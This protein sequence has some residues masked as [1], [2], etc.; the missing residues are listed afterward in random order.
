MKDRYETIKQVNTQ[1]TK[2][3]GRLKWPIILLLLQGLICWI[4][5]PG[6]IPFL[7]EE[8]TAVREFLLD[9]LLPHGAADTESYRY[10]IGLLCDWVKGLPFY[11]FLAKIAPWIIPAWLLLTVIHLLILSFRLSCLRKPR[12]EPKKPAPEKAKKSAEKPA[13][14]SVSQT[15]RPK[16]TDSGLFL[17]CRMDAEN[18]FQELQNRCNVR[19][20]KDRGI[21]LSNF[22]AV[23]GE[24][25]S[26]RILHWSTD[27][28]AMLAEDYTFRFELIDGTAYIVGNRGK[29]PMKKGVPHTLK[30][31]NDAGE[32]ITYCRATWL[33]GIQND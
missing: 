33:G 4:R 3:Q 21:W 27:G 9:V 22:R 29:I 10:Y 2:C 23:N 25:P 24:V 19:R 28:S 8:V 13:A 14:A 32:P 31:M 5:N 17:K 1:L 7:T 30:H 15:L 11:P 16:A 12:K 18:R 26:D 20:Y 6:F